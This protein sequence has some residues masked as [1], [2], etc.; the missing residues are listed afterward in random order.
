MMD[1]PIMDFGPDTTVREVIF[2][3]LGAA[4]ACWDHL[5]GAGVFE[6]DRCKRIGDEVLAWLGAHLL[7]GQAE[8]F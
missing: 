2:A 8:G 4:S 6:S 7:Q 5:E 3:S 1:D